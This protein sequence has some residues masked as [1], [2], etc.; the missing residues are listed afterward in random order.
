MSEEKWKTIVGHTKYMVSSLGRV[1]RIKNGRIIKPWITRLGYYEARIFNDFG[2]RVFTGVHRFVC[3][4][5]LPPP[6]N[7]EK[8]VNHIDGDKSNNSAINLEWSSHLE[9]IRHSWRIGLRENMVGEKSAVAVLNNE[10]VGTIRQMREQG[11]SYKKISK[12][13]GAGKT[14][15]AMVCRNE[16]WKHVPPTI[17]ISIDEGGLF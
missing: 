8:Y 9:N 4:G 6:K 5:F 10:K 7:G 13:I 16:T 14:T 12:I 17:T 1:K 2:R 11:L 15:V 3:Q